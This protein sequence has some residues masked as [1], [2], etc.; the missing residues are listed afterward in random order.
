MKLDPICPL[1]KKSSL[2]KFQMRHCGKCIVE[3]IGER[4]Y[5]SEKIFVLIWM[6]KTFR[7]LPYQIFWVTHYNFVA[8]HRQRSHATVKP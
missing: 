5:L 2:A 7:I 6:Y 4:F 3:P 1:F 8:T